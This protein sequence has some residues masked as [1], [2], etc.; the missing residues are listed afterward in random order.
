MTT[1]REDFFVRLTMTPEQARVVRDAL[2]FYA[3]IQC[4]Q[5]SE[6][7]R[8]FTP[9]VRDRDGAEQL[10]QML[11]DRLF[12]DL[13]R[14]AS[15]HGIAECPSNGAKVAFD[16]LQV[17]RHC[18]FRA[19]CPED[20]VIVDSQKPHFVSRSVPRPVAKAVNVL[21]RLVED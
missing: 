14:R 17:I 4:G 20:R 9:S 6:L 3:R 19:R 13:D 21:D 5:F 11:R 15:G 12:P 2:D 7:V 8:M 1:D 16:V 10:A 18:E